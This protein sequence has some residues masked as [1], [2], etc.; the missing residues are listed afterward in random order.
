M[1]AFTISYQYDTSAFIALIGNLRIPY[2]YFIE[3]LWFNTTLSL[4]SLVCSLVICCTA[5]GIAAFKV[6]YER[7]EKVEKAKKLLEHDE[8]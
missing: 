4:L 1:F 5:V 3:I 6:S 7:A 8:N 2:A